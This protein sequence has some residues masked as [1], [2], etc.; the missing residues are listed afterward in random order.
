MGSKGKPGSTES[1]GGKEFC[2][3]LFQNFLNN[4]NFKHYSRKSSYGPVFAERFNRTSRDH[5]KKIVFEQGDTKWIDILP[6]KT[7]QYNNRLDTSTKIS[8]KDAPLK[9][10]EGFLYNMLLD[11]REKVTPKFQINDI[12]RTADIKKTFSK[13]DT[14]NWF[15]KL[16]KIT[17]IINDTIPT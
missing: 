6:T 12:A 14:S 5:P 11:K 16:C 4:N 3:N 15:Y 17:E 2:N 10:N 1:D 13:R 9:K 8:P 7:K